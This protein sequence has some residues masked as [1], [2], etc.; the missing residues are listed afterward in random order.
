MNKSIIVRDVMRTRVITLHPK[1]N[2]HRAKEIFA[3]F[4]IHHI[5]ICVMNEIRGIISLG[6]I[7]YLQGVVSDSF[8]QFLKDKKNKLTLVED[9]MTKNPYRT[10]SGTLLS[11]AIDIML[12]KRV[13]AL[14]VVDNDELVGIITTRD[15]MKTFKENLI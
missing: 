5:P 11:E 15:I 9:V 10:T 6:D 14:P 7:L 8:D 4:N 12:D 13:N 2:L 1:D 3:E